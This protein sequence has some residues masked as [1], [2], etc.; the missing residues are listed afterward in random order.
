MLQR[1]SFSLIL[2][3]VLPL[4][5]Y[6][7]IM[8]G[9]IARATTAVT[10][11]PD[12]PG[13]PSRCNDLIISGRLNS[14]KAVVYFGGDIQD[15]EPAMVSSGCS[16]YLAWSLEN[17]ATLLSSKFPDHLIV[18]VR[19]AR[20]QD[21]VFSCFDNFV[22][23]TAE[24]SPSEYDPQY[25]ASQHLDR[26]LS[27]LQNLLRS[28]FQELY[29]VGFSKGCVILNQLLHEAPHIL[30]KDGSAGLPVLSKV[31]KLYYLDSGHAS[32]VDFWVTDDQAVHAFVNLTSLDAVHICNTPYQTERPGRPYYKLQLNLFADICRNLKVLKQQ[33]LLFGSKPFDQVTLEDHFQVLKLFPV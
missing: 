14:G 22:Q 29:I 11:L 9:S 4:N 20:K 30:D 3:S 27:S 19:P 2:G 23:S 1:L 17:T 25:G 24:I 5:I 21:L 28:T 6:R 18:A 32:T 31:K 13:S 26:L 16:A 12:I 33:I 7:S 10:I 15:L 8:N